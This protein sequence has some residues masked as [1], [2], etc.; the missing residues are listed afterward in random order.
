MADLAYQ[1]ENAAVTRGRT[2]WPAI[3]AGV[4]TFMAIWLVFGAL[5]VAIFASASPAATY[6]LANMGV[7]LGIW[8]IVLTVIAMYVAGRETGRLAAVNDRHD[9]LIHGMA[10]FGLS[11]V[12]VIVLA[13]LAKAGFA[14]AAS[15]ASSLETSASLGVS[16][17][18]G[19]VSFGSLFLGWLA[20]L[21]GAASNVPQKAAVNPVRDM[22]PAA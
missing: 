6:S 12:A 9:G 20:A 18:L 3:W 2:S 8:T 14:G 5:G 19:W 15:S 21:L 16:A 1:N 7:G 22:R 11:A 10:M 4:F 17:G 13:V